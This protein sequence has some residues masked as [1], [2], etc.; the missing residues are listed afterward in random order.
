MA[1]EEREERRAVQIARALLDHIIDEDYKRVS[2]DLQQVR[3]L[4]VTA[5]VLKSS[6]L[7]QILD[8]PAF[9]IENFGIGNRARTMVGQWRHKFHMTW[10]ELKLM[11]IEPTA[12]ELRHPRLTLGGAPVAT[13]I[14]K[15]KQWVKFLTD[16]DRPIPAPS[17]VCRRTAIMLVGLGFQNHKH[18]AGLTPTQG[19]TIGCLPPAEQALL[20]RATA[21][22]NR[23][24]IAQQSASQDLS[25]TANLDLRRYPIEESTLSTTSAAALAH[26][27]SH[28]SVP[29][30][31]DA[32]HA[33]LAEKG[34]PLD[35]KTTPRKTIIAMSQAVAKGA[36]LIPI[37]ECQVDVMK[38]ATRARSM[39][40][41]AS[42]LNAWFNF[43]VGV[44]GYDP[45][46]TLPPRSTKDMMFWYAI[47]KNHSTARNYVG[48]VKWACSVVGVDT[49]WYNTDLHMVR[50]GHAKL[51]IK[52]DPTKYRIQQDVLAK[53]VTLAD[54]QNLK[55]EADLFVIAYRFLFRVQSEAIPLEAGSPSEGT[56]LPRPRHSS[57]FVDGGGRIVV[58]L[59][60]RKNRPEGSL[61]IRVCSCRDKLG[62]A[63][64]AKCR[65][66]KRI[67]E[68]P[69]GTKLFSI[70]AEQLIST[71]KRLLTFIGVEHPNSYGLK[72]FR[73]GCATDMALAG[74]P[75]YEILQAGEWKSAA[76]REY[77]DR[78]E[79][80]PLAFMNAVENQSDIEE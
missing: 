54:F 49:T 39:K 1:E 5:N 15:V 28:T 70:N 56:F 55:E 2:A 74:K 52:P 65:L 33:A 24:R 45:A 69:L 64:C 23:L 76:F 73:R 75:L 26:T 43:A 42:Q 79:L 41:T 38:L 35:D 80:E 19:S 3:E 68:T 27:L 9:S 7:H 36:P 31:W 14:D 29:D 53:L 78:N 12:T 32:T 71:M 66:Q 46:Y 21:V 63:C 22:A 17:G 61:L 8:D 67:S 60:R 44:L 34:I 11:T 20:A 48:A 51:T 18:L 57:A 77:L 72:A 4:M 25:L 40:T 62:P 10:D 13:F 37:L 47:F 50:D 6:G 58:R 59:Q 30:A 16:I